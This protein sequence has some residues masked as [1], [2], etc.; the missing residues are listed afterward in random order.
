MRFSEFIKEIWGEDVEGFL[1]IRSI[2][3]GGRVAQE[4][5]AVSNL[6]KADELVKSMM[7]RNLYFGVCPRTRKEGTL[8][9]IKRVHTL[10]VDIDYKDIPKEEIAKKA[11]QFPLSPSFVVL[12][13]G[14]VHLYFPL[15]EPF[16]ID[17]EVDRLYIRELLRAIAK[18]WGGD[19]AA[20]DL[21]RILRVPGSLNYKY[22]PPRPV[23][24]F[25][26]NREAR[27]NL[28]DFEFLGVER[29]KIKENYEK[30][31]NAH[32]VWSETKKYPPDVADVLTEKCA[33]IKH[34]VEDA[35]FLPEP[36][37]W[38]MITNLVVIENAE[39][40]IHKFSSPYPGY[41][42]RETNF[43]I[44]HAQEN[45]S[46]GI[47]PHTC[48][49][50]ST[51]FDCPS[52]CQLRSLGATPVSAASAFLRGKAGSFWGEEER[53]A[54]IIFLSS[55]LKGKR[56]PDKSI[57]KDFVKVIETLEKDGKEKADEA[58]FELL[59]GDEERE[60]ARAYHD[61]VETEEAVEKLRNARLRYLLWRKLQGLVDEVKRN[62]DV[63][64]LLDRAAE[65]VLEI[66]EEMDF[67]RGEVSVKAMKPKLGKLVVLTSN[68]Q[69]KIRQ[70]LTQESCTAIV[71]FSRVFPRR[72][73]LKFLPDGGEDSLPKVYA[74][75][76]KRN[77]GEGRFW[78][79]LRSLRGEHVFVLMFF[80][81][82]EQKTEILSAVARA[83]ELATVTG[84]FI[85][86]ADGENKEVK[87]FLK[88]LAAVGSGSETQL[89]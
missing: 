37:W 27:F 50:I 19:L 4:F 60:L 21:A 11:E 20:T 26:K 6:A 52:D 75:S 83:L 45:L 47:G 34:C 88:T 61:F 15:E 68:G 74:F 5:V 16:E 57:V 63:A 49:Y 59:R 54:E 12:S 39:E 84:A 78:T 65:E 31:K 41:T 28:P 14:G 38:A 17:T 10:W 33:F 42:P 64:K 43:K 71:L 81:M 23:K 30:E 3:K 13:G 66:E 86:D 51:L 44:K 18:F 77:G 72:W 62:K 76:A 29:E 79:L 85:V 40:L 70:I 58:F 67:W 53:K 1:E 56:K 69:E 48:E 22:E 7:H 87:S 46:R 89:S 24:L 9:A 82:Q 8:D 32:A 35:K 73:M 80:S 25:V 36:H 55:V 2:S